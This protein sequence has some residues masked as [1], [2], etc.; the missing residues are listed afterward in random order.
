MTKNEKIQ[1]LRKV[2]EGMQKQIDAKRNPAISQQNLTARRARIARGMTIDADALECVQQALYGI[3]LAIANDELPKVLDSVVTK[4]QI[5]ALS[6]GWQF[7][8]SEDQN[9]LGKLGISDEA[10]FILAKTALEEMHRG[11]S[12]EIVAKRKLQDLESGLIGIKIP[13]FFPTPKPVI[14]KMIERAEIRDGMKVLEPSAGKGDIIAGIKEAHPNT[15]VDALEISSTLRDVLAAKGHKLV[16][17]DF[18][19]HSGQYDRIIMNPPFEKFADVTHVQHAYKNLKPGGRIVSVMSESPFFRTD[20][21]AI[22]FREWLGEVG[23]TSEKLDVGSF[24]GK[25][26]FRQTGVASRLVVIDKPVPQ[27]KYAEYSTWSK[28]LAKNY[29]RDDLERKYAK[30]CGEQVGNKKSHLRAIERTHSMTSNSQSR[31]QSGNVVRGNYEERTAIK[32]ALEIHDDYPEK[33]KGVGGA[34]KTDAKS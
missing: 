9:R 31:A 27:W 25:N 16:G 11:P 32:W 19:A 21:T 1:K 17:D 28:G 4:S 7:C 2:A 22:A 20:K 18:L 30:L 26:A 3:A 5:V 8:S 14:S 29:T 6:G 23:G 13:G 24:T 12:A 33:A 15:S 10:A 34:E